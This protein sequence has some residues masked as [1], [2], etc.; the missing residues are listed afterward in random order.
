MHLAVPRH[1]LILSLAGL[2]AQSIHRADSRLWLKPFVTAKVSLMR[3]NPALPF[4]L[5][6]LLLTGAC[7]YDDA[8]GYAPNGYP[9]GYDS[10]MGSG[11]VSQP[12]D[13]FGGQNVGS[14]AVFEA[15]LA[16]YGQWLNSRFGRAF[17]PDVAQGWRPYVNGQWGE[18]RLWV[19]NDPWGWAT[20]HYGRWGFDDRIG[21]V[22]APGT[23][24]APSWVAFRDDPGQNVSGWAP[25]PPNVNYSLNY[26]FGTGWGYDNYASWYGPSWV[27]VPRS[28]LYQP[29]FGGR[30]LPW[31]YGVDYWGGSRWQYQPGWG[32][33]PRQGQIPQYRPPGGNWQGRPPQG[34]NWQG[35]PPQGGQ[36]QG[37]PPQSGQWQG[38]PPQDGQWQD[39]PR[40]GGQWQGNPR[41]GDEQFRPRRD[42]GRDEGRDRRG[43]NGGGRPARTGDFGIPGFQ[44]WQG[45]GQP[46]VSPPGQSSNQMPGRIETPRPVANYEAPRSM[47]VAPPPPR[48]ERPA[49]S[50]YIERSH[51]DSHNTRPE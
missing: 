30:V 35:R 10:G 37:R 34:G 14:V 18:N 29:G 21:W 12:G 33:R 24:W 39:G 51:D 49:P 25:I 31:N 36:W 44:S 1:W 13:L 9:A 5:T 17:R 11:L 26:G 15:P 32:G 47:P 16:P 50:A 23:E 48:M 8:T 6:A 22:W 2:S 3:L 41:G 28:Y 7:A 20:D 4:A 43:N 38:R 27:W 42:G 40:G 46:P 45:G 19:S